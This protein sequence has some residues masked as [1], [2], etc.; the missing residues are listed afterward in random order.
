MADVPRHHARTRPD[1]VAMVDGE[2]VTTYR[3]F[4]ERTAR[5]ADGL[6]ALGVKAGDRI[7]VLDQN[8][9]RYFEILFG[10]AKIGAA[11][12]SVNWRLAPPEIAYILEDAGVEV[13]FVGQA[14]AN[15]L[16]TALPALETSSKVIV[17]D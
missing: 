12:V 3:M 9:D 11:I 5:V 10:A 16:T 17:I 7:G 8:S 4:N 13:M 6:K 1:S 14:F 2:R 15:L